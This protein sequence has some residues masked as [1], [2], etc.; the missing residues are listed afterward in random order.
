MHAPTQYTHTHDCTDEP[1]IG[2]HHPCDVSCT[3]CTSHTSSS[4]SRVTGH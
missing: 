2:E 3:A 1:L 4:L